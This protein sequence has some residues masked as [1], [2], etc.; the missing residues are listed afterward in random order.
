LPL[1]AFTQQ[2]LEVEM[3]STLGEMMGW[4]LGPACS[5]QENPGKSK[6]YLSVGAKNL[7]PGVSGVA[8]EGAGGGNRTNKQ[9][10]MG[11]TII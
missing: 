4:C 1:C 7:I 2:L 9:K 11:K 8:G 3:N 6:E 10:K 5:N